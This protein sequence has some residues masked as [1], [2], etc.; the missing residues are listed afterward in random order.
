M[1]RL[2][3]CQVEHHVWTNFATPILHAI[4]NFNIYDF[5]YIY[6]IIDNIF[7]IYNFR[8]WVIFIF[9]VIFLVQLCVILVGNGMFYKKQ[10]INLVTIYLLCNRYHVYLLLKKSW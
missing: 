1:G 9:V 6:I 10:L 8:I 3:H 4:D 5:L 7:C 2:L